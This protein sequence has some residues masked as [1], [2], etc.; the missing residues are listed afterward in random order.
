VSLPIRRLSSAY[1][2]VVVT[3]STP[4][5]SEGSSALSSSTSLSDRG[6][7]LGIRCSDQYAVRARQDLP[8]PY[9]NTPCFCSVVNSA[10]DPLNYFSDHSWVP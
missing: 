1:D 2:T 4:S 6:R 8:R 9:C 10:N 3:T 7:G 5:H